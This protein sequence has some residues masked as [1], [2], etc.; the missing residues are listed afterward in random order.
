MIA[1]KLTHVQLRSQHARI[2]Q[3]LMNVLVSVQQLETFYKNV[4]GFED[5]K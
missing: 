4:S 3:S 1:A 2:L 5:A